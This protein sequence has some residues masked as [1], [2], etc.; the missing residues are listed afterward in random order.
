MKRRAFIKGISALPLVGLFVPSD[1]DLAGRSD[2]DLISTET[3]EFPQESRFV[4][5]LDAGSA[6]WLLMLPD[7][8]VRSVHRPGWEVA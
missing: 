4:A 6:T 1:V 5:C 8:S 7:G 2:L 3:S